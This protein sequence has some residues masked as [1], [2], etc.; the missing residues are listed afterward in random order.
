MKTASVSILATA[1][2]GTNSISSFSGFA[3]TELPFDLSAGT[4]PTDTWNRLNDRL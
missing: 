4:L 2:A 1:Q 3:D